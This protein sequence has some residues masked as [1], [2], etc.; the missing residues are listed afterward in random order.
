MN[1]VLAINKPKDITS[2]DCIRQIRR[3]LHIDK[4]GHAGT[5]DP[6]ATGVLIVL[7]GDATKISNYMLCEDKEYE[8]DVIFGLMTDTEDIYGKELLTE[9]VSDITNE[10]IDEI[11]NTLKGKIT[12]VPPMYSA[13]KVNGKKLY[14][15]ARS[16]IEVERKEREIEVISIERISDVTTI[17]NY[18]T[19]KFKAQVSKGTYVRTLC[20]QIGERLGHLAT[21]SSLNRLRSGSISLAQC[22]DL[23]AV[24]EGNYHL[25]DLVSATKKYRQIEVDDY[26]ENKVLH[27]MKISF[28]D[29]N[30]EDELVFFVKGEKLIGIYKRSEVCY[31]AERVWN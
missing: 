7:L 29:L 22:Y 2:F 26:L 4:I 21:M 11:L 15:Y 14:E 8:F 31:K 19:C 16:G 6:L 28:K 25:I 30:V 12:Q 3:T 27:G 10:K 1:G 5:L 17:D 18:Q 13:I 24:E 20:T 9:K 23:K